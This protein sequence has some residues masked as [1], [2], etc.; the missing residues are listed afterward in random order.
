MEKLF[1]KNVKF[2]K[3]INAVVKNFLSAQNILHTK[4]IF[5]NH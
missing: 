5:L 2:N 3:Q 4:I 1:K